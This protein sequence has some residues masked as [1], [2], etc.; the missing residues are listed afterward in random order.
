MKQ[1]FSF[2]LICVLLFL[3]SCTNFLSKSFLPTPST[4]Q[5]ENPRI[6]LALWDSLTAGNGVEREFNY[7]NQL[8]YLL[9]EDGYNY[10]V[11][12]AGVSGD[13]SLQVLDR[14]PLYVDLNPDIVIL[15]VGG[16]DGLQTLNIEDMKKNILQ[17][18]DSFPDAKMVLGGIEVPENLGSYV[19]I[20]QNAYKEIAQARPEVYFQPSFLGE[21]AGSIELNQSDRVHPTADWYTKIA[22]K[23]FEFLQKNSLITQ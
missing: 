1:Y 15:V 16:N 13:T 14:V 12:N 9:Q 8:E 7:P 10:T 6:I 22:L 3:T 19:E 5:P 23:M 2:F 18:I 21:V 17:I 20:F 4:T 11:V